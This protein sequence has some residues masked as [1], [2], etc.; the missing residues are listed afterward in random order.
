V[1][2]SHDLTVVRHMTDDAIVMRHGL[3]VERGS[4]EKLFTDPEHEYTRQLVESTP[5][6]STGVAG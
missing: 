4:S 5:K 3:V 2:V 1:L 6:I